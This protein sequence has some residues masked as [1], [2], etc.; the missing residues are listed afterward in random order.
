MAQRGPV[1]QG[2]HITTVKLPGAAGAV[3][4]KAAPQALN[5]KDLNV[6]LHTIGADYFSTLRIPVLAGRPISDADNASAP[7]VIVVNKAFATR[8]FKDRN[9]LGMTVRSNKADFTIVGVSGDVKYARLRDD[10]PPTMY[11]SY[12]QR[13]E[14]SQWMAF[15][16]RVQEDPRSVLAGI[17]RQAT[18][19]DPSVPVADMLTEQGV[20][21]RSLFVE[22]TFTLLSSSFAGIAL[23]LACVGLYGTLSYMVA[24]RTNEIGVRMALGAQRANILEMV[25][26]DGW[27]MALLGIAM[28]VP[29]TL[30]AA[31]L[32]E[33]RVYGISPRD[34]LSLALGAAL[35]LSIAL[36]VGLLPAWRASRVD[37][38]VALKYE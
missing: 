24:R 14:I 1:G 6:Y 31:K 28:G 32:V 3:P 21:D 9:P 10:A 27:K 36:I 4:E 18:E 38:M 34:P 19:L 26:R 13:P 7:K 5:S 25:M 15:M 37:P 8:Y 16:V 35:V 33:S 30:A 22:R 17:E 29:L 12:L 23:V 2:A 20:I 11:V